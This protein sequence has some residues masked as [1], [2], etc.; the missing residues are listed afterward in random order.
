M[1]KIIIFLGISMNLL[2][3][4]IENEVEKERFIKENGVLIDS[5]MGL[6]W[7]DNKK[8]NK[9]TWDDSVKYCNDLKLHGKNNWRLPKSLEVFH[10]YNIKNKFYGPSGISDSYW[11]HQNGDEDR[12]NLRSK[13]YFDTYNKKVKI[14]LNRPKYTYYNVRCVSGPSYAS[15]DEIKKV[16]D[17]NRKEA[18]N[19]KLNNYYTMLQ[20]EDSIKEYRSFLKK[21]PNTSINQKIEKRLKELYSNEIKKLKKENTIMAYEIFLKNNPNSSIEDD[22]T[23]EIYK[24]VKEEDNIAGYEWY[25]NKYSKSSNAKQAIE[26]IHKLAFEEAKDIDTISSYNTFV[27]NYP[28]AKEVKQANKKANELER[29]EY[30]SLGLL[31][32]IGTNEK[33]DRKARALLIKAKQIERYP[34]D[35]NLNGSSSMGYKIVAN[36][37]Y[38]L[39]QKEFIESEATLRHLES[40]EFKDFV[41]DFRYVMKNI[42]RTLNQTN[43]YIKEVVSISKRGFEDAKADREMAAYYTKQHRDW[44]KFMH[45]RDKGYN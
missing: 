17:K 2:F 43:S 28:L 33:L 26:Q 34:L 44:E 10:L 38:E 24:L 14:S 41:K 21:Y 32:F 22:I 13:Y 5:F 29:E 40:Q 25:V 4:S 15:K 18:I 30:T 20:K 23:K 8:I 11:L 45:F 6:V 9:M 7:E 42:Q 19:K 1:F 37:M 27:F 39:L 35:N 3:A 36:R 12:N 16:I 31:S